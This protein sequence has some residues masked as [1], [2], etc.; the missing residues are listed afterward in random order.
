M[1]TG[2]VLLLVC[3][4]IFLVEALS[5]NHLI[6]RSASYKERSILDFLEKAL[7][8][9]T[10]VDPE[11]SYNVS[12]LI[13]TKG[14]PVEEYTVQTEDG[15]LLGVQRIPHGVN[16][17]DNSTRP[18]I[19]L[20]H[21]L[22]CSSTNWVTNLANES[23]GFILADAGFDVWLG[24]VRGNTYAKKH[25][26]LDPNSEEFWKFSWDEMARYDLPAMLEFALAKS[27]QSQ[28]YYVGHSQ[29][30][31]M[32]FSQFSRDQNLAKKVRKF[33][34]LGP[35]ATVGD[36]ESPLKF[37][38]ILPDHLLYFLLGRRDFMPSNEIFKLLAGTL[39]KNRET[40]P[41]CANVLFL[42]CGFDK[43]ELNATRMP[44][45]IGHTPAGTSVQ[46]L[47]HFSQMV[48]SKLFQSYDF[49]SSE[50]N[51]KH[52]NQ[53]I[54]PLHHVEK[55]K[56]P[57]VLFWAGKDLLADPKDVKMLMA[58]I[59]HLEASFEI[60]DW[61]HLDFIWGMNAAPVVYDK[62]IKIIHDNP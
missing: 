19:F 34:A 58:R 5:S 38:S 17:T 48:R 51:H 45:Y 18:V 30:T 21:G 46:N 7:F 11:I 14:Y 8:H 16:K 56:T 22:L 35:V 33:F 4:C 40:E 52:Y 44:V 28:L 43:K 3:S 27:G 41:V 57:T 62:I 49:G 29:G 25:I 13:S 12:Q 9:I 39:C 50:E 6:Y 15:Y 10:G 60:P 24:N 23:L 31:L 2:I 61:D 59:P 36:I 55:M 42:I 37:L 53:S 32:A 26:H 20:L 47:V 1:K 54:P